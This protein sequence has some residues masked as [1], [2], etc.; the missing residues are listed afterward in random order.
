MLSSP[1]ENSQTSLQS[2]YGRIRVWCDT[3]QLFIN[4][5]KRVIVPFTRM[6]DLRGL[7]EPT[8]SGYTLQM[9]TQVKY[10]GLILD[11][12]LTWKAQLKM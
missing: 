2:F 12:E 11:K 1:A 6:R 3:T 5:Q 10:L 7:K 8:L 9:T 4:P